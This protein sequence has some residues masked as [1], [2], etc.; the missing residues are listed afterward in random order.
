MDQ[1]MAVPFGIMMIL[2][3]LGIFSL[4]L[5][6]PTI[7]YLLTLQKALERCQ[8]RNRMMQPGLV[9]LLLIPFFNLI[10]QFFVVVNLAGSL[11]K[12]FAERGMASEPEP[13]KPIGFAMCILNACGLI[14]Y[15]NAVTWIGGLVCWIIYWMKI[16]KYS[17]NLLFQSPENGIPPAAE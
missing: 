16:A 10:W 14:P 12:E 9:W 6:I 5:F 13:G 15:V 1:A 8:P 3:V 17:R 7:F 4:V 2:L 11:E